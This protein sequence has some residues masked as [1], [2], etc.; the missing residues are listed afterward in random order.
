MTQQ[1]EPHVEAPG[2]VRRHREEGG[3]V[4]KSHYCEGKGTGQAG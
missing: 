3:N 1:E 2:W 4:G